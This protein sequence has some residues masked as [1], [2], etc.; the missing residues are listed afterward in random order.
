[1]GT[2]PS[3]GGAALGQGAFPPLSGVRHRFADVAGLP[4]HVAEA[5]EGEPVVLLHGFPQHWWE[6]RHVIPALSSQYRVICPDL[7]GAGWTGAPAGGYDRERLVADL[8]GVLDALGVRRARLIGHDYG[9][10]LGWLLCLEHPERVHS[11]LSLSVPHPWIR[12]HPA[13]LGQMWRLWFQGVIVTPGVGPWAL[14]TWL[15]RYLLRSYAAVP[16]TFTEDDL[17]VFCSRLRERD[18][19]RAGSALYRGFILPEARRIVSGAYRDA[20]VD[21]PVTVLLGARDPGVRVEFLAGWEG[22]A[23]RL[24]IVTAEGASHFVADERPDVVV[25]EAVELFR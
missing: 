17:E 4:V 20:R 5:G 10:V 14:R 19:A 24:R 7:R 1:M 11:Y 12:F 8:L 9:A 25:A 15:T 18:R 13:M 21:V 16:G 2:V 22:H 6:W 23:D 3:D